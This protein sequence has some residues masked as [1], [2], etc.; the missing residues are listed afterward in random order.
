MLTEVALSGNAALCGECLRAPG[1][2][3]KREAH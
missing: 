2:A 3:K 1:E